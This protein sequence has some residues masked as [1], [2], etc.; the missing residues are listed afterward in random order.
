MMEIGREAVEEVR[1]IEEQR[2]KEDLELF[3]I[4]K[5]ENDDEI[6]RVIIKNEKLYD[7]NDVKDVKP[8]LAN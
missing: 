5:R 1:L 4:R 6:K 7:N 3:N 2:K 8:I